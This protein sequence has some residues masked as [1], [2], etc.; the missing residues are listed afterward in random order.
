MHWR[1]EAMGS[2]RLFHAGAVT[3]AATL[4]AAFVLLKGDEK[5]APEVVLAVAPAVV[6]VVPDVSE[7]TAQLAVLLETLP[8][9]Q[10]QPPSLPLPEIR[11]I[12][13][14]MPAELLPPLEPVEAIA[15]AAMEALAETGARPEI[16]VS[17][18]RLAEAE[19]ALPVWTP[20][21]GALPDAALAD[22]GEGWLAA[23]GINDGAWEIRPLPRR[24]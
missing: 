3:G 15:A 13:A 7:F 6:P 21:A 17:A 1:I 18:T 14:A 8:A 10:P 22:A 23:A 20:A 4:I 12:V 11:R 2:Y 5:P 9:P 19:E 24:N 16:E